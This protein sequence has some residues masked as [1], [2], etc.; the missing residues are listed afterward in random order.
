VAKR[1]KA[2]KAVKEAKAVKV[3]KVQVATLPV[4]PEDNKNWNTKVQEWAGK[5]WSGDF[6]KIDDEKPLPKNKK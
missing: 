5:L 1:S 3:E 2:T 4:P 6:F